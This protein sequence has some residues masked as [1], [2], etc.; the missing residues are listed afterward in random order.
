MSRLEPATLGSEL[1]DDPGADPAKVCRSLR[2]IARAN[3]WFGG[4]AAV[5]Y[6]LRQAFEDLP[7]GAA[8][9]LLDVGAGAGDL[10]H[11]ATVWAAGRGVRLVPFGL[12]RHPAAARLARDG[13]LPTVLGDGGVLPLRDRSVDLVLLSQVAHHF[14]PNAI[15]R[16]FRECGRVARRAVIVADLRRSPLAAL[17]FALGSRLLGF[18]D[19]TV[20]DGALSLRRGFSAASLRALLESAGARAA[21]ARRTG[22]RLVA[23]WRTA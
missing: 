13:G 22:A 4:A 1:L 19:D 5:R 23:V 20:R 3:R 14:A 21:V 11:M 2:N 9:T 18:D 8:L 16:L 17:G 12:E 7:P 10:T 15:V 6:G